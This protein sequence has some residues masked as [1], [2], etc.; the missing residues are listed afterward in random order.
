MQ[1]LLTRQLRKQ[2]QNCRKYSNLRKARIHKKHKFS[3]K[4]KECVLSIELDATPNG[5]S[6]YRVA[7]SSIRNI[8]VKAKGK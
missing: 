2:L 4:R 5:V 1:R 7:S 8:L 6:L 3:P